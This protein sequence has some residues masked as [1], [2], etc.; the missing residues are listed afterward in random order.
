MRA[1]DSAQVRP[2]P[3]TDGGLN[4]FWSPDSLNIA[5]FADGKLKRVAIAGGGP[6]V[7]C[8]ASALDGTWNREGTILFSRA[9]GLHRLRHPAA[10]P[11]K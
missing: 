5:F 10:F 4:P 6:Q 9:D 2:L 3:G 7:V 8:D 1:L 11:G